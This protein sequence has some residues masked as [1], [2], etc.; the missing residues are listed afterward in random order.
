MNALKVF[1]V[2]LAVAGALMT[3]T[4]QA[5]T[6]AQNHPRRAEVNGRANNERARN[7]AATRSGRISRAQDR[8]LNREDRRIKAQQRRDARRNG[9]YITKGQQNRLNREENGVNRQRRTDEA[10]D[11]GNY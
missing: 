10:V 8:Q 3:G 2:G 4:A 11:K 5:G 6:W 7:N 9:G 1:F